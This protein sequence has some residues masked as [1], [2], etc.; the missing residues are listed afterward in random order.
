MKSILLIFCM[1][2]FLLFW[3]PLS[4]GELRGKKDTSPAEDGKLIDMQ[5]K[6]SQDKMEKGPGTKVGLPAR[7][8]ETD[9][10]KAFER[11]LAGDSPERKIIY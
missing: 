7:P 3:L 1:L 9:K 5:L 4:K 10:G 11:I 2:F 8:G 6:K